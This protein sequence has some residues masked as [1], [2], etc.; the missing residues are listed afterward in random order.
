M[1][2]EFIRNAESVVRVIYAWRII[3]HNKIV[4]K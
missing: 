4:A 3:P 2:A 1:R